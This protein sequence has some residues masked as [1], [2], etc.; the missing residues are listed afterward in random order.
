MTLSIIIPMLNEET[1]IE[2]CLQSINTQMQH[3]F[4]QVE[5]LVSDGGSTDKSLALVERFRFKDPETK[6]KVIHSKPGRSKQMNLG[7]EKSTGDLLLFLHSDSEFSPNALQALTKSLKTDKSQYGYFCL[8]FDSTNPLSRLYAEATK[9]NSIFL[10]Y[11]DCGIFST[12]TFFWVVG[13]FPD[14]VLMEDLEFLMRA[15]LKSDP[16]LVKDASV[17]TSARRFESNGYLWQQLK[18]TGLVTLY[19]FGVDPSILKKLYT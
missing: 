7:A 4:K 8:A 17:K 18:N 5:I 9:I 10:H 15:R 3:G 19:M 1:R 2:A 16:M 14:I 13:G 6:L 11:G 12:R